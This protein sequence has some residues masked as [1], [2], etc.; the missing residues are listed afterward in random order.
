M[1][2]LLNLDFTKKEN[3]IVDFIKSTFKQQA[4]QKG[5]IA[6]SG[7]LDSAVSLTLA[8][9]ALSK[10]NIFTLQL[11]YKRQSVENSNLIIKTTAIPSN[12]RLIIKLSRSVDKLAVKLNAK[13][14]QLRFANLLARARMICLFDQAKKNKALVIGTENKSENLLGY[15]TRFGD[16]ASDIEPLSH[17]YKTQVIHLAKHLGISEAIINQPPSADLWPGQTDEAELDFSYQQADPIIH[18]LYDKQ[19]SPSAVINQGFSEALVK[20][21]QTRLQAFEFKLNVPYHL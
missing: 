13:K 16:A 1:T 20:K 11:P 2:D 4:F 15:F 6:V 8:V 9:K 21:V 7:G 5:I 10:E 18:L 12:Q 3:Q 14:H 19:L 17:L